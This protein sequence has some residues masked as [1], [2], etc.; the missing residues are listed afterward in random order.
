MA[1][2]LKRLFG[3][4]SMSVFATGVGSLKSKHFP[5]RSALFILAI[6]VAA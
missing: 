5:S 2:I 6:L 4:G 3:F 1:A